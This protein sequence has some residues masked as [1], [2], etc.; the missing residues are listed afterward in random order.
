M[1]DAHTTE[2]VVKLL[3]LITLL[4]SLAH[5]LLSLKAPKPSPA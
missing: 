1:R 3:R 5:A 4:D 2:D